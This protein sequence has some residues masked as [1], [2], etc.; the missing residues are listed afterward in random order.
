MKKLIVFAL[1][2][3]LLV[4][5][6]SIADIQSPPGGKQTAI[7]KL[8][9]AVGNI[10]FGINE[11][12]TTWARTVEE[13]GSVY[14]ASYG[15]INGS[16]RTLVRAGYGVFEFVTFPIKTYKGSYGPDH[17]GKNIWWDL[18]QGYADLAP[19][20]GFQTKFDTGRSQGWYPRNRI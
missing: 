9:R 8:S 12:P 10:L 16:Y 19:E 13:E 4:A 15:I 1:T 14:A 6:S 17:G 18:N 3:S 11:V 5:G 20:L 7:R 2:T